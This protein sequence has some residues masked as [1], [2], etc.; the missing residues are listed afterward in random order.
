[1]AFVQRCAMI[2]TAAAVLAGCSRTTV[3]HPIP[4]PRQAKSEPKVRY[5][6][7]HKLAPE[8]G[9]QARTTEEIDALARQLSGITRRETPSPGPPRV[10]IIK[11]GPQRMADTS[12]ARRRR[13]ATR[14]ADHFLNTLFWGG[15][16]AIIGHQSGR[17][18]EGAIIGAAYGHALDHGGVHGL[19]SPGTIMGAAAGALGGSFSGD[20]GKGALYGAAAGHLL[21]DVFRSGE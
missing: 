8:P 4:P 5:T 2:A 1:M 7:E 15:M 9:Y 12:Y 21:D 13:R 16:G 11:G 3:L 10:I 14:R 17:A 19:L 20:A 18:G 6:Y